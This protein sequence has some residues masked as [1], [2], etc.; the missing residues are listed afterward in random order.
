MAC[1]RPFGKPAGSNQGRGRQFPWRPAAS[2]GR[3]AA[4][5]AVAMPGAIGIIPLLPAAPG[6]FTACFAGLAG[7]Q[8]GRSSVV[9]HNLAKVG[10]EG[11]NPF[12]RS[13]FQNNFNLLVGFLPIGRGLSG[14]DRGGLRA[15][16]ARLVPAMAHG[17]GP[18]S[19]ELP[20]I[21]RVYRPKVTIAGVAM[22][23]DSM[24]I[25]KTDSVVDVDIEIRAIARA[26]RFASAA[27][28]RIVLLG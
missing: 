24:A 17:G 4:E 19:E 1:S 20:T 15:P 6:R 27:T 7:R 9:E 22:T 12:A 2:P 18:H 11:S 26:A 14:G 23:P 25:T 8:S 10:V 3:V 13:K 21:W 16:A 28:T 5:R